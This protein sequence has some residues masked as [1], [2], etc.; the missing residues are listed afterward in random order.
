M[1]DLLRNLLSEKYYYKPVI[2]LWKTLAIFLKNVD[3]PDRKDCNFL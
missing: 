1:V 3:K 2:N